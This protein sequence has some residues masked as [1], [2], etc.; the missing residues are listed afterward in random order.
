MTGRGGGGD[1]GDADL[2]AW[3][4]REQW[5]DAQT[6]SSDDRAQTEADDWHDLFVLCTGRPP[7]AAAEPP[8]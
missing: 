7:S 3:R 6:S 5:A 4:L 2:E 8:F 1:S